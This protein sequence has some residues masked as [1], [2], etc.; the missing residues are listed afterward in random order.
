MKVEIIK[1]DNNESIGWTME[2]ENEKEIS[3]LGIIRDLQFFGFEQTS[4]K[5]NG[6][7][8]SNDKENNPGILSW[9]QKRFV[10]IW[11]MAD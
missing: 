6:R 7:K 3:K 1:N 4:I 8:N 10:G 5:Y 9:I 2:G 11:R